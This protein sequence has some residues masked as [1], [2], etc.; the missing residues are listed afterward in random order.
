MFFLD[1]V[2]WGLAAVN[3][4]VLLVLTLLGLRWSIKG[5]TKRLVS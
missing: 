2:D 5:L 1:N 4:G 3:A